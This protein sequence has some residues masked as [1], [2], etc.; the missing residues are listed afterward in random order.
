MRVFWSTNNYP[1]FKGIFG[2]RTAKH[3]VLSTERSM[4][5]LPFGRL[6]EVYT[7]SPPPHDFVAARR[8]KVR[9]GEMLK[10]TKWVSHEVQSI[11]TILIYIFSYH[12]MIC[13]VI[14]TH[15]HIYIYIHTY[16]DIMCQCIYQHQRLSP[17]TGHSP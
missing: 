2:K 16:I 12:L 8:Y 4:L 15:T 7:T 5:G 10:D 9:S 6:Q 3:S 13:N 17:S 11:S 1:F 14:A